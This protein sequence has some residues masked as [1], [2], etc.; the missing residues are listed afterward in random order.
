M[1]YLY[2]IIM[3]K[4]QKHYAKLNKTDK[5]NYI[6]YDSIYIKCPEKDNL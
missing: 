4:L 3:D 5:R 1:N 6:L 2:N